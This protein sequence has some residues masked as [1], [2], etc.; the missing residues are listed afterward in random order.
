MLSF[1]IRKFQLHREKESYI[2]LLKPSRVEQ[3]FF[4]YNLFQ[5]IVLSVSRHTHKPTS[6]HSHCFALISSTCHT[7]LGQAHT[8][9][10]ELWSILLSLI[11]QGQLPT[12]GRYCIWLQNV[13][14][15][16]HRFPDMRRLYLILNMYSIELRIYST[17]YFLNANKK[18]I[19]LNLIL[20]SEG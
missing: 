16:F 13:Y 10:N 4:W 5:L 12:K 9:L 3:L 1:V 17:R 11:F 14:L 19:F 7:Y 20:K 2:F 8:W 18:D 6:Y 15:N